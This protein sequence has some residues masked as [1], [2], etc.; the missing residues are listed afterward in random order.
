MSEQAK[1]ILTVRLDESMIQA[2]DALAARSA[3]SR[4]AVIRMLLDDSLK[5]ADATLDA[6][7]PAP[8]AVDA[9]LFG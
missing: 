3:R 7:N 2:L 8:C 6:A 9:D 5:T 1:P 4:S